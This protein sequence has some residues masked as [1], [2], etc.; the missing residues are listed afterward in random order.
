[1]QAKSIQLLTPVYHGDMKTGRP[2]KSERSDFAER[3]AELR[4]ASGLSQREVAR[5]L[6]IAQSSYA[7]WERY[8]VA[9]KPEQIVDVA[10]IIGVKVE[11]LL[12]KHQ[13]KSRGKGPT[14]K[15]QQLFQIASQLPKSQQQKIMDI[16]EPFVREQAN[17]K[18]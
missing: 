6:G 7:N 15:M 13:K 2:T 8:N 14:G 12:T 5:R 1:M 11:D 18:Q 9:L 16:L 3:L 10:K 17:A 4:E